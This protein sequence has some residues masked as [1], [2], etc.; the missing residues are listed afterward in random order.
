MVLVLLYLTI[1]LAISFLCS[2]L[3]AV[4]LSTP[5]SFI[6]MKETEGTKGAKLLKKLKQDID[7]P[8]SAILSLNTI[9][10]TVGA[11]GVGA[12]ATKVFGEAY[13]GLISTILTILI[14]VLS[15]II[16]KTVGAR[17]WRSL[18][19]PSASILQGMIIVCYPF[20]ILSQF[21][22]KLVSDG[23]QAQSVSREEVSA[24]ATVGAEEGVL[25]VEENKMIQN[26][27]KLSNITAEQIMTPRVV[28]AYI[29]SEK[30]LKELYEDKECKSYS[31]IPV[32]NESDDYITG[33]ILR[34]T[35][36]E[37]L[38]EDKFDLKLSEIVRPVLM[39][40]GTDSVSAV[41]EK[42]LEKKEHISVIIDEYGCFRGIVTMEDIIETVLGFEI[43]DE[44]D[45]IDDMQELARQRWN[46]RKEQIE[47]MNNEK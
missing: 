31:R 24:M 14:L 22:T 8:I 19:V 28:V 30:S 39:F 12:E 6:T 35:V 5:M 44:N 1:A 47:N 40:Q 4:L 23:K 27:L 41:W 43:V 13:F 17:Y 7:K 16:P 32:Y 34:Q 2:V 21:I 45:P 18:A 9:A 11:A 10:H 36:L 15:E 29:S 38:A 3:E 42:M 25:K 46:K 20:V 37:K 33:Y 26:M